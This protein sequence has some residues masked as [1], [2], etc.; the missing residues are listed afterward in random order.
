VIL[1]D[2]SESYIQEAVYRLIRAAYNLSLVHSS[3]LQDYMAMIKEGRDPLAEARRR[4][5]KAETKAE[6]EVT[7]K[8]KRKNP[9]GRKSNYSHL[10]LEPNGHSS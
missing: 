4:S 5:Q 8:E 9:N 2:N 7:S 3:S 10:C 6:I 1:F